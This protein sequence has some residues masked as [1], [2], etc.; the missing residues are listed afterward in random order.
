[1]SDKRQDR[2]DQGRKARQPEMIRIEG[3]FFDLLSKAKGDRSIGQYSSDAGISAVTYSRI[4]HRVCRPS[5]L[6]L[7]KLTSASA[8]PQ[9]GITYDILVRSAAIGGL[10]EITPSEG[11]SISSASAKDVADTFFMSTSMVILQEEFLKKGASVRV[12]PGQSLLVDDHTVKAHFF[13][14][15][16][17]GQNRPS[18][19]E[20]FRELL[21][22][23]VLSE[24]DST[25]TD[26]VMT[27]STEY[28]DLA[29]SY[30]NKLSYRGSL[31]VIL[32]SFTKEA[33]SAES[34]V[35]KEDCISAYEG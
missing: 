22:G 20:S 31:R 15:G 5:L 18:A 14:K 35:L 3:D 10:I 16:P 34:M 17:E 9:N 29:V 13:F 1:M 4:L 7:A 30:R 2:E 6:T 27:D 32:V 23:L 25:R 33:Y 21:L 8:C 26:V 12:L 11:K 28:Y 19:A 24:P